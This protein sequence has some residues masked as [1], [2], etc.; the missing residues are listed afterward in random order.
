MKKQLSLGLNNIYTWIVCPSITSDH[1]IL[2][3]NVN[4]GST[5]VYIIVTRYLFYLS[6]KL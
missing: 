5:Y 1:L 6:E 3:K 2:L 4:V